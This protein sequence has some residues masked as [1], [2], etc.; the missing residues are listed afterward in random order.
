MNSSEPSQ[1]QTQDTKE[2]VKKAVQANKAHQNALKE[3]ADR[4]ESELRALNK[5]LV[6]FTPI[7]QG[8]VCSFCCKASAT[9]DEDEDTQEIE[10]RGSILIEGSVKAV[11]PI[12]I[13]EMQSEVKMHLSL[14]S[15][16][17]FI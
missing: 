6:R 7:W 2:L 10:C 13:L 9:I 8:C 15:M 11:P 12:S 4:L 3:H 14:I 17:T 1:V 16:L 5:L